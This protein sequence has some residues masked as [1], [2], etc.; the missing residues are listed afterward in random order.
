MKPRINLELCQDALGI[1]I[2]ALSFACSFIENQTPRYG[3]DVG[4]VQETSPTISRSGSNLITFTYDHTII[5]WLLVLLHGSSVILMY[6]N[7]KKESTKTENF[8]TADEKEAHL[9][10]V[11]TNVPDEIS[12]N[13]N[14]SSIENTS[15]EINDNINPLYTMTSIDND[16]RLIAL[17]ER[18]ANLKKI[19]LEN[20]KLERELNS[21]S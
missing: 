6:D 2:F 14:F 12:H 18:K 19:Q 1:L 3:I 20:I 9:N 17:E 5:G 7:V 15:D 4:L 16:E 21:P 13:L 8:S 10:V 11:A